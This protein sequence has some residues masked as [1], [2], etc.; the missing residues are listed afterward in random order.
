MKENPMNDR[1]EY[2]RKFHGRCD[3]LGKKIPWT[4]GWNMNDN[5]TNGRME[6]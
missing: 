6:Y 3:G 4:A 5:S 1:M 2:E